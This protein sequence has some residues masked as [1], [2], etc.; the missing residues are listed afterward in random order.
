M[1][2]ALAPL[3]DEGVLIV[4]TGNTFHNLQVFRAAMQGTAEGARERAAAFDDWLQAAV[5][6]DP[7][8]RDERLRGWDTAPFARFAQPR[9]DHLIPLM[10]AA[11][12][13]GADRGATMWSG[14]VAG[15]RGS[16]FR[17]G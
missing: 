16:S 13:A 7:P 1:G 15:L 14:T 6:A 3:R 4:G 11:G 2:Q 12:A 10:V 8:V 9:E 5:T 17:F